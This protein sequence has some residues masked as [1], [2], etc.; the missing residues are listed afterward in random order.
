MEK[1]LKK[2]KDLKICDEVYSIDFYNKIE[3]SKINTIRFIGNNRYNIS[4][5]K[6]DSFFGLRQ[7]NGDSTKFD[8]FYLNKEEA[9][10]DCINRIFDKIKELEDQL[11]YLKDYRD[12]IITSFNNN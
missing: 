10:T 3:V 8:Y 1:E 5:S 11:K 9:K 6:V 7:F 2:I 12:E 4:T